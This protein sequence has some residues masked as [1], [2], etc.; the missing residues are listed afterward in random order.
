MLPRSIGSPSYVTLPDSGY[1]SA[2]V[3]SGPPQPANATHR[4]AIHHCHKELLMVHPRR[5]GRLLELAYG[6][7]IFR[8]IEILV[9][10]PRPGAAGLRGGEWVASDAA[11]AA[12][13]RRVE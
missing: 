8:T 7:A 1:R 2:P 13:G 5:I 9:D 4:P 12:I 6:D 3:Y 10:K 11:V